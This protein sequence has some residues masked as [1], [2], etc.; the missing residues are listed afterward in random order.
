MDEY[1]Y[2]KMHK[3]DVSGTLYNVTIENAKNIKFT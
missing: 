2:N 3:V 1:Q